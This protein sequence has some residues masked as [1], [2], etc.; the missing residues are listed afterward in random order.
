MRI[1]PGVVAIPVLALFAAGCGSSTRDTS[2]AA[3]QRTTKAA[4]CGDATPQDAAGVVTAYLDGPGSPVVA[5]KPGC[6]RIIGLWARLQAAR[7]AKV[8]PYV[9]LERAATRAGWALVDSDSPRWRQAD[10]VF[11]RATFRGVNGGADP[12][13]VFVRPGAAVVFNDLEP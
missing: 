13:F 1:R 11:V 6:A 10:A 8:A 2:T 12:T 3:S 7:K 4:S 9:A 5:G